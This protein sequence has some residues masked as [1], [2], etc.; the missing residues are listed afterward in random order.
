MQD[1]SQIEPNR[2]YDSQNFAPSHNTNSC[3]DRSTNT[4]L[5][6]YLETNNQRFNSEKPQIN[7]EKMDITDISIKN[8][9]ME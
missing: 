8:R 7:A 1:G 3:V 5:A 4:Y 6:Q 9:L 2:N